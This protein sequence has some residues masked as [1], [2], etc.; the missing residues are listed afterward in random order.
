MHGLNSSSMLRV[1]LVPK[2]VLMQQQQQQ[3]Q[4]MKQ[5]MGDS[6]TCMDRLQCI[7]CSVTVA[8]QDKILNHAGVAAMLQKLCSTGSVTRIKVGTVPSSRRC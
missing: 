2:A 1:S 7:A 6:T 8:D 5:V 4:Q 3:Q